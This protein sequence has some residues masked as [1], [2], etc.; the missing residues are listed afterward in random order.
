MSS[1]L[2]FAPDR[3]NASFATSRMRSRFRCASVRG[4]RG[5]ILRLL[6]GIPKKVATGDSLR[7]SYLLIR[8]HSPFYPERGGPVNSDSRWFRLREVRNMN[9]LGR[10]KLSRNANPSCGDLMTMAERELSA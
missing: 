7:L 1:R 10:Y 9:P 3:V 4:F 5:A 2:A 8:R 6:V